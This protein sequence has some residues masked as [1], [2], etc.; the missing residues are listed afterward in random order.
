MIVFNREGF[1]KALRSKICDPP[2]I[3]TPLLKID[4]AT[5][6]DI[7]N[8]LPNSIED[9]FSELNNR[10]SSVLYGQI[11]A[12]SVRASTS[13]Y[14]YF[15]AYSFLLGE[16]LTDEWLSSVDWHKKFHRDHIA[17]QLMCTYVG[18]TLLLGQISQ[19]CLL[20]NLLDQ[21]VE[22]ALFSEECQYLRDYLLEMGAP[23]WCINGGTHSYNLWKCMFKESFHIAS[24]YHDIGYPWQFMNKIDESLFPLS[25]VTNQMSKGNDWIFQ[26][27]KKRL[28]LYPL[29]GY[30]PI[31]STQSAKWTERIREI[32]SIGLKETHGLPGAIAMLSLND[33]IRDY[34]THYS[35]NAFQ[36]FCIEWATM[37][38]M[39][40]DFEKIYSFNNYK[41]FPH[42][43]LR[44]KRD[45]LSFLLTLVDQIQDFGRANASFQRS[46]GNVYLNYSY[47]CYKVKLIS[48][49]NKILNI[50]H[51]YNDPMAY[52]Q[53]SLKYKPH[54][55]KKYFEPSYGYLDYQDLPMNKI[56][57]STV[58]DSTRS[59]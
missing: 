23:K 22:A 35:D 16:F 32:I 34:P 31:I 30:Q 54:A 8:S 10:V 52:K 14:D 28:F 40:H 57:L 36:R 39:M 18:N 51:Y 24:M 38:I 21:C 27:Y 17:H 59:W 49:P 29:N 15:P 26:H 50:I 12:S 42:I 3:L 48:T 25:G 4:R 58:F 46:N 37:A 5:Y 41:D 1:R 19:N 13:A 20:A 7:L 44:F 33:T 2:G 45:P 47:Q 53:N 9:H 56:E 11:R 43:R 6:T 55:Q